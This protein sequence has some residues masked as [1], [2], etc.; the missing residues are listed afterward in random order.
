MKHI[1]VA[2]PYRG[3]TKARRNLNILVCKHA[4]VLL[5]ERGW[6]PLT[7]CQNTAGFDDYTKGINDKFWLDGTMEQMLKCDAVFM[8]QGWELSAGAIAERDAALIKG[9]DVYYTIG[10]VPYIG[11]EGGKK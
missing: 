10:E 4:D 3:I 1:Y 11:K 6:M 2:G 8:A 9:M 5:S 7:P